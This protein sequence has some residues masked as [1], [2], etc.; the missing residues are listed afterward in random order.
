MRWNAMLTAL[1]LLLASLLPLDTAN[2]GRL[3]WSVR[4]EGRTVRIHVITPDTPGPWPMAMV[5]HGASGVGSGYMYW[6]LAEQLAKRGIAAAVVRYYD[7]LPR[8]TKRKQSV[9]IFTQREKILDRVVSNLLRR[10]LVEGN[11]IGSVGYSLGGFHTIALAAKDKRIAAAV[12]IAGGLSGHIP[13]SVVEQAAPLLLIH[14]TRDRI[15]P[16]RR[17][18]IARAAWRKAGQHAQLISLKRVGHVPRG[19]IQTK[20]FERAADFIAKHLKAAINP[21][22]PRPRPNHPIPRQPPGD[23]AKAQ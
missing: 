9:R 8:R 22:L 19:S 18:M 1:L 14:G 23:L 13:H 10:N 11:V 15:V 21:P 5:L 17:S 20:A 7:G 2:A 4:Y 16:H 6:P 12:S 3:E